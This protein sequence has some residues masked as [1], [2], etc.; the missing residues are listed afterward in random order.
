LCKIISCHIKLAR[1]VSVL[2]SNNASPGH[3]VDQETEL[4]EER[5]GR[6]SL[7]AE[8]K[9]FFSGERGTQIMQR[10]YFDLIMQALL[11]QKQLLEQLEEENWQLRRQLT[12]LREAEGIFVVIEGKR[13]TLMAQEDE[14]ALTT[15]PAAVPAPQQ[16]SSTVKTVPHFT[17]VPAAAPLQPSTIKSE[18]AGQAEEKAAAR[19]PMSEETRSNTGALQETRPMGLRPSPTDQQAPAHEDTKAALRRELA[20][21]FLLAHEQ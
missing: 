20:G 9:H 2:A 13:F 3:C 15:D 18:R 12:S 11:K 8:K 5:H 21:S 1:S 10:D 19:L 4:G 14:I 16:L 7:G 17:P 6:N